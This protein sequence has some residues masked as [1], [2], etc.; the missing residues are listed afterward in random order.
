MCHL[1]MLLLKELSWE[2]VADDDDARAAIAAITAGSGFP[3]S[4]ST[5]GV[6]PSMTAYPG[7]IFISSISSGI[8]C[9]TSACAANIP[10]RTATSAAK[11]PIPTAV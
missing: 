3:T 1:L 6:G 8:T 11:T 5:S 7:S 4:T 2:L 9:S 10:A